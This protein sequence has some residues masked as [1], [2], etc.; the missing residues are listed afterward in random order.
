MKKWGA[1]PANIYLFKVNYGN[2]RKKS[3]IYSKLSIKKPRMTSMTTSVSTVDFK[4][5]NV[6]WGTLSD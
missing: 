6:I 1:N 2:T 5:V 4:Q 3:E